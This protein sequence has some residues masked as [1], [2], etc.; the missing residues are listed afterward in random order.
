[1][2]AEAKVLVEATKNSF[3]VPNFVTVTK[4][5]FPCRGRAQ[6]LKLFRPF[7]LHLGQ[8]SYWVKNS[9]FIFYL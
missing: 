1:L 3:V 2:V 9:H 5:F 6:N 4:P 7:F 8:I